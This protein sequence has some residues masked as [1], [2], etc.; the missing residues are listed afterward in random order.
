VPEGEVADFKV[1]AKIELTVD[2]YDGQVF[3][4]EVE[5]FDARLSQDSRTLMV[6]GRLKNPD[7]KLLPGMFAQVAVLA[8]APKQLVTVPRTAVTYTLYGDSVW[9]VKEGTAEPSAKPTASTEAG[10]AVAA[11]APPQE[12]G[13]TVERRFVHVGPTQQGRVAI[14]DG[15]KAGERV[16]TSGQLK[17]HPGAA[18]KIDNADALKPPAVM[19]KQ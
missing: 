15:V 4:G 18:V 19:P 11:D 16:V 8:G 5:A 3:D 17:L 6:R 13:L 12:P 10:A 2:T 14:L 7:R 1:G 9:V